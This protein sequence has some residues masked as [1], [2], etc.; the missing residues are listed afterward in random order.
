M[1][2]MMVQRREMRDQKIELVRT[3]GDVDELEAELLRQLGEAARQLAVQLLPH[4]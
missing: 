1:S 2:K 3:G 4:K